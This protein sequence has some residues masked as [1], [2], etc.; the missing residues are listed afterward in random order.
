[1]DNL[2]HTLAGAAM[3]EAGLKRSTRF[4]TLALMVSANLPDI[5]VLVFLT[6][7]PAVAFR[8]GWTHGILAQLILPLC[9]TGALV[10]FDRWR[11]AAE[12]TSR[13]RPGWLL[14]LACAGV[15]SHVLL[16][17]LNTYGVRLLMPVSGQWFYGDAVF[18]IDPWIWL[19]LG[20][21][22]RVARRRGAVRP[23]RVALA[24]ATVYVVLMVG[25]A[26]WSARIV[27]A[28]WRDVHGRPPA[29]L[30]AGPVPLSPLHRQVIVDAGDYYATGT[31]RLWPRLLRFDDDIVPK[32]DGGDEVARAR[33]APAV[34]GFL[35][36]SR[37]PFWDVTETP[38]GTRVT[39]R[40]MRFVDRLG[41]RFA[42]SVLLP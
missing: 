17:L 1:M 25:A 10:A 4:G 30:M 27:E 33:S 18:I 28:G 20:L 6:S 37:F 7:V 22:V 42:G 36:W 21:G 34:A 31:L 40:D 23:A 38:E 15:Y 13:A 2:C 8:R 11:P 14:L 26:A 5:D 19:A 16:D 41:G 29:A 39:V 35:V 32:D 3:G 12:G 9:L 24:V